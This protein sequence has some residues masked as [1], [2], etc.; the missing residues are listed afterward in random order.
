MQVKH[1]AKD[2][3]FSG[4]LSWVTFKTSIQKQSSDAWSPYTLHPY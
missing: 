1:I 4:W 3:D 2:I